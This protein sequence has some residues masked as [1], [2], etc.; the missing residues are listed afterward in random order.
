MDYPLLLPAQLKSHLKALRQARGLTQA[1]LGE[2]LGLKQVR[3]AEIEADP[4]VI[5]VDQLFKLL[6]A[7]NASLVLRDRDTGAAA[8]AAKAVAK[9]SKHSAGRW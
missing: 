2:L 5:S 4:A 1:Q 3:I 9:T 8:A 6:S 7:L